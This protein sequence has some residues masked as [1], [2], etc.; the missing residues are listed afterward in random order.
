MDSKLE[1]SWPTAFAA[2]STALAVAN[3]FSVEWTDW[4]FLYCYGET[5]ISPLWK[6]LA[7][8]GGLALIVA[9][10]VLG[11]Q[12]KWIHFLFTCC[13]LMAFNGL[14]QFCEILFKLGG[15]CG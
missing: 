14:P 1:A 10:I 15:S 3:F 13:I 7:A 9:I 2:I 11:M 5:L 6:P 8:Y 4:P 12:R